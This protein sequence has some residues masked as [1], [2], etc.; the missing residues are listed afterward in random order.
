MDQIVEHERS[1]PSDQMFGICTYV[2]PG[3]FEWSRLEDGQ[4]REDEK[5]L[6][7]T[8]P[9]VQRKVVKK[10]KIPLSGT[11]VR[12]VRDRERERREKDVVKSRDDQAR[13][14][15]RYRQEKSGKIWG[16]FDLLREILAQDLFLDKPRSTW[17]M[18]GPRRSAAV[19]LLQ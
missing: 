5:G 14:S 3:S 15:R 13:P 12:P 1:K 18:V 7:W 8:E 9:K 11:N 19:V 6:G 2:R 10:S 17:T 4:R 16:Y